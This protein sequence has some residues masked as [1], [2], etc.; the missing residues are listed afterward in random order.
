MALVSPQIGQTCAQLLP[1][2]NRTAVVAD[3]A[4]ISGL[5]HVGQQLL[6]HG[7]SPAKTIASQQHRITADALH[8]AVGPHVTHAMDALTLIG[9]QLG[10]LR[11]GEHHHSRSVGCGLQAAHQT[12]TRFFGHGV[13]AVGAVA[14]V[15]KVVQYLPGQAV[16]NRQGIHRWAD[17]LRVG[18]HQMRR[19]L[20][21]RLGLDVGSK[22]LNTVGD[23]LHPLRLR[24]RCRNETR[25]QGRG[26]CSKR[27]ALQHHTLHAQPVQSQ[28][29]REATSACAHDDHRRVI[30]GLQISSQAN[31]RQRRVHD[32]SPVASKKWRCP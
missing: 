4:S 25:R 20:P 21:V 26:A 12:R 24:A 31:L 5:G 32:L 13:H 30:L 18:L 3:M 2:G 23:A 14:G 11:L 1:P 22:G 7:R 28:R 10:H 15:Q 19:G 16:V 27:I 9:P 29:G 17:V 8:L 6:D